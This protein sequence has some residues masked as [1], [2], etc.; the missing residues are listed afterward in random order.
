[1]TEDAK[2]RPPTPERPQF[3][4]AAKPFAETDAA[5][6]V[7]KTAE[8]LGWN[9]S[10]PEKFL[11]QVQHVEYGLSAE[12]EFAAILRWLGWCRFVHRLSEEVLEDPAQSVWQVPDLFAVFRAGDQTSSALIE[13]K[14]SDDTVLKFKK[15]YL[16]RLR[17]YASLTN[18]PL[19][20]AWRPRSIGFWILF[21]PAIAQPANDEFVIVEFGQA[22]KNDLMSLLAGDYYIIPAEGAGLRLEYERI[23]E[24]EPTEDGY[25]ALFRVSEAYVHDASGIRADDVPNSIVWAILSTVKD[26][27]EAHED[28]IIQ[29]FTASGG[30][31]R[32]QLVL[33][34]AVGFSINGEERIHWKAVGKNLD[35]IV[36]S[37]DLL[38]DAQ[39]RFG[40]F[41]RYIFHQ[42][43][44]EIP[45]FIPATWKGRAADPG[46]SSAAVRFPNAE[47]NGGA[48]AAESHGIR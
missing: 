14:T 1:M 20:I 8:R 25:Q 29:S 19:L 18:Q 43:P 30:M 11:R 2:H 13:V 48:G 16:Q 40:T 34:T 32:A 33:R 45:S 3:G 21:D 44:Q 22:I 27:Q 24:K 15:S 17:A 4:R 31:T 35:A 26:G 7:V 38:H 41:L 10:D 36:R 6:A 42:Q 9:I 37:D 47:S 23:S 12:I 46:N 28:R 5:H 39:A